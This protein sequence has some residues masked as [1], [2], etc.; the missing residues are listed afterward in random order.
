M[1]TYRK[2][3]VIT[4]QTLTRIY[5]LKT[6]YVVV[7]NNAFSFIRVYTYRYKQFIIVLVYIYTSIGIRY[8]I[9]NIMVK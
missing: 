9:N 3:N 7:Y 6:K 5:N 8:W 2:L 1:R 4:D